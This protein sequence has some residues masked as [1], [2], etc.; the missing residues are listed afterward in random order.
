MRIQWL[1]MSKLA[2]GNKQSVCVKEIATKF[3]YYICTKY[4]YI[5]YNQPF[6]I[7]LVFIIDSTNFACPGVNNGDVH[8]TSSDKWHN[9]TAI[10]Q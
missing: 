8:T 9:N 2:V 3:V 6:C 5:V 7:L 4:M 10:D 1:S